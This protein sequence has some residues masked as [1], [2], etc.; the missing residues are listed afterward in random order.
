MCQ[1]KRGSQVP[2]YGHT[3]S[4]IKKVPWYFL[5]CWIFGVGGWF[6]N[7]E[8]KRSPYIFSLINYLDPSSYSV[9]IQCS[10][11][12]YSAVIQWTEK[13]G[14]V[15]QTDYSNIMRVEHMDLGRLNVQY[16]SAHISEQGDGWRK[17]ELYIVNKTTQ[18]YQRYK[19]EM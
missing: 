15:H 19:A 9:F 14:R 5:K 18:Y 3:F 17:I 6:K 8:F 16:A 11:T 4:K 1:T 7:S 13:E 10:H 12:S 2:I